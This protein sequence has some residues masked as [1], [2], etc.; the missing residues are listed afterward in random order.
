MALELTVTELIGENKCTNTPFAS[1][2][3]PRT[4][5]KKI[6]QVRKLPLRAVLE[7]AKA[8]IALAKRAL[9]HQPPV[10]SRV[11]LSLARI[12]LAPGKP[13]LRAARM[14]LAGAACPV[15]RKRRARELEE[16]RYAEP[17]VDV[18]FTLGLLLAF[19]KARQ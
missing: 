1:E 12:A 2:L 6:M 18:S 14:A 4:L 17:V 7:Q 8:L 5:R 16:H 19:Q 10:G 9:A 3:A 11:K 15:A 13:V